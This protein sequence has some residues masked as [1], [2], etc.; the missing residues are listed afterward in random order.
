MA[1]SY[2]QTLRQK[3][4]DKRNFSLFIN[5]LLLAGLLISQSTSALAQDGL[6]ERNQK[7]VVITSKK[8]DQAQVLATA[9]QPRTLPMGI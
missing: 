2:F 9:F 4:H 1:E 3:L 7:K 6:P 5:W 8:A